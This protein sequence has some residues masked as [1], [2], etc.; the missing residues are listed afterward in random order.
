MR[1]DTW[2]SRCGD[3]LLIN[4]FK[5]CLA[6]PPHRCVLSFLIIRDNLCRSGRVFII[7]NTILVIIIKLPIGHHHLFQIFHV[8]P[9]SWI[10]LF[11]TPPHSPNNCNYYPWDDTCARAGQVSIDNV[12]DVFKAWIIIIIIIIIITENKRKTEVIILSLSLTSKHAQR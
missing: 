4:V 3:N 8:S 9:Y 10:F 5:A 1:S 7:K 2:Q 12:P 6:E 11:D